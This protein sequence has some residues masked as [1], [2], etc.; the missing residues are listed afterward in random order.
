MI[1][2]EKMKRLYGIVKVNDDSENGRR[3]KAQIPGLT[4]TLND[5]DLP[6]AHP[7]DHQNIV[8]QINDSVWIYV[9]K[10][11]NKEDYDYSNQLYENFTQ[12][13]YKESYDLS[14]SDSYSVRNTNTLSNEPTL[15]SST[16]YPKN[17]VIKL[18]NITVEF[19]EENKEFRLTDEDGS[20]LAIGSDGVR[21]KSQTDSYDGTNGKKQIEATGGIELISGASLEKMVLGQTLKTFIDGLKTWLDSHVHPTPVGPSSAP[22]VPSPTVPNFL[23][24]KNKVD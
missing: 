7:L 1:L 2:G 23:S 10:T 22:L 15:K 14:G 4:E 13:T 6:W 19:D 11:L 20:Y 18:S 5:D 24:N 21:L 8:P 3:I 17:R 16:N 9:N 12:E